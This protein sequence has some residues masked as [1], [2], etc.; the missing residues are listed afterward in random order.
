MSLL[1]LEA[2]SAAAKV[3][4]ACETQERRPS[5]LASKACWWC[6]LVRPGHVGFSSRASMYDECCKAARSR[7]RTDSRMQDL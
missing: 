4:C 1:L 7:T 5:L 3:A 6:L 2:A